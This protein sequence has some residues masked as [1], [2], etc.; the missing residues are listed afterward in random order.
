M[1][2]I[3]DE[4]KQIV[5]HIL[6]Y[7]VPDSLVLAFG[8]RVRG[9]FRKYSDLDLLVIGADKLSINEWGELVEAFQESE[10]PFRVDV[11]D[12]HTVS[13]EFRQEILK[14]HVVLKGRESAGKMDAKTPVP[15]AL[16]P[17]YNKETEAAMQ[18]AEDIINGKITSKSYNSV[19]EL[20]TELDSEC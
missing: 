10:L 17:R 14:N 11:V 4:Q 15:M 13:V 8:S 20:F 5:L 9:D 3:T 7:Y 19:K 18:E 6:N 1:I 16:Q 12:G 2:N